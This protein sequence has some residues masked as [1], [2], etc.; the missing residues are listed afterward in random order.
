MPSGR[1]TLAFVLPAFLAVVALTVP[2]GAF[3]LFPL[4]P[5]DPGG[6]C[7][8]TLA[9]DPGT[10][11]TR[12]SVAGFRFTDDTTGDSTSQ[13]G[14]G[15]SVTWHWDLPHCHSVTFQSQPP[16]A[17]VAGTDG[18]APGGFDGSEPQLVKPEGSDDTFTA[19]FE[20]PGTYAYYCVHH[21]SVGMVG[22]V[23]VG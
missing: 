14:T 5:G 15:D 9:P 11:A 21:Q 19:T 22:Q 23:V 12:V 18:K 8:T 2:A 7:G 17:H 4:V 6:N 16:G 3:H 10:G 20:V 13:V 1:A